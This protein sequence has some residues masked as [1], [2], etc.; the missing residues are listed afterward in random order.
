MGM[1][2]ELFSSTSDRE[3]SRGSIPSQ[4]VNTSAAQNI[5]NAG[6]ESEVTMAAAG[7][8]FTAGLKTLGANMLSI[9]KTLNPQEASA[10]STNAA[11]SMTL[12]ASAFDG[13]VK[14]FNMAVDRLLEKLGEKS[15]SVTSTGKRIPQTAE[16]AKAMASPLWT[17][18]NAF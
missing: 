9:A 16:E 18:P 2:S 7:K 1:T 3:A 5:K 4:G 6:A 11:A 13:G 8:E 17:D 15:N 10:R 14:N 12:D